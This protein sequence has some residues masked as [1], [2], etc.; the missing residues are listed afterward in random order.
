MKGNAV[1]DIVKI[2]LMPADVFQIL[3]GYG[4]PQFLADFTDGRGERIIPGGHVPGGGDVAAAGI[5]IL[6][7]TPFLQ[8]H[9]VPSG[10]RIFPN[11]PHVYGLV[12]ISLPVADAALLHGSGAVPVC[13]Q[14][15]EQLHRRAVESRLTQDT[16][17][18][19]DELQGKEG[20]TGLQQT[21]ENLIARPEI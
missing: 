20:L 2:S 10:V 11:N 4:Q 16:V 3:C 7:L 14:H 18:R 8:E 15:V 9:L 12:R 1:E 21:K 19:V 6:V 5:G 13:I 17:L